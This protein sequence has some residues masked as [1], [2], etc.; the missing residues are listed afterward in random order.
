MPR[1]TSPPPYSPPRIC[2]H[3]R[4]P[5]K[6]LIRKVS[7]SNLSCSME[8]RYK[9]LYLRCP[10]RGRQP[11]L[12]ITYILQSKLRNNLGSLVHH[13]LYFFTLEEE[14]KKKVGRPCSRFCANLYTTSLLKRNTVLHI[15]VTC[16]VLNV[17][18][19]QNG[20]GNG[21]GGAVQIFQ[22]TTSTKNNYRHFRLIYS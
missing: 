4:I 2:N 6:I 8:C 7:S 11:H 3:C 1:L 5:L 13:L 21:G 9:V 16:L 17:S 19:P 10:I 18:V 12:Q 22:T 15:D 20:E 14:E